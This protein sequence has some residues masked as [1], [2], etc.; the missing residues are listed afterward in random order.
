MPVPLDCF[1]WLLYS[2][3]TETILSVGTNSL[4]TD[5]TVSGLICM[6]A[7][8]GKVQNIDKN[9]SI[10]FFILIVPWGWFF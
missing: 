1:S 5:S 8:Q 10:N 4:T 7:K 6:L 2:L 3:I 9:I